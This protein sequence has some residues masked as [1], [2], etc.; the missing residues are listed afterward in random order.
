MATVPSQFPP[1]EARSI[2][3]YQAEVLGLVRPDSRV[4]SVPLAAASGR[5]LARDVVSPVSIPVFANSAMDG[6]AVRYADVVAAPVTLRVVGDVA[7]GSSAD[8]VAGPGECVRIMTGAPLPTFAD[9]VVPVED[10]EAAFGPAGRAPDD[11]VTTTITH[12]PPAVG[13]YVRHAGEDFAAGARVAVA[14]TEITAGVAAELAAVGLVSV[15]VRPRPVVAVRSTGD[16]LVTDGSPLVRGQIYE[17][18][19]F[20]LAAMLAGD[21]AD[22]RRSEAARDDADALAAW[23]DE[24]EADL[25]V[26][27]GGASVGAYDVVRDVLLGA[28]GTFRSVRVQPGKPQG[29]AVWKGTPVLSLPGNPLSAALSYQLFVQPML[30]RL[31]GRPARA[32]LTAVTGAAWTSPAGRRQIV[33]VRLSTGADGR[34]IAVPAHRRGSASHLVSSLAEADGYCSVGEDVTAVAAGDL[35]AVRWL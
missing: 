3:Q 32:W 24:V 12:A 1:R 8:P 16:E 13:T 18:N 19:S 14:G 6:Y 33:P 27:T 34:L 17:S 28:G 4:E 5:V 23:L 26:L 20:A 25:V 11:E 29:W 10:T 15:P 22:V 21:G 30:D 2:E 9:T 35:V 7:A 31:L